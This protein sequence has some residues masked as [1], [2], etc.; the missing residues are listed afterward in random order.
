MSDACILTI[1][2]GGILQ[3]QITSSVQLLSN[4]CRWL[5]LSY[6]AAIKLPRQFY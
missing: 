1:E 2:A 6:C 4:P 5:N 3:I